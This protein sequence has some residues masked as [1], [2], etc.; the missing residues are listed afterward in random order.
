VFGNRKEFD[1]KNWKPEIFKEIFID[2]N[3]EISPVKQRN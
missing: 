1:V 2:L 3:E